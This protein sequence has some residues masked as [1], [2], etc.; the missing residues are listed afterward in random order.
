MSIW[1]K[2]RVSVLRRRVVVTAAVK[3]GSLV[4]AGQLRLEEARTSPFNFD[5]A[6]SFSEVEGMTARRALIPGSTVLRQW[7][8]TPVLIEKGETVTVESRVGGARLV[9]KAN[10]ETSGRLG[11]MI[12]VRNPTS[13]R[14]FQAKVVGSGKVEVGP[15]AY[16]YLLQT[17][18]RWAK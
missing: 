5:A 10:A 9:L 12:V 15:A 18:K 14:F 17:Q 6:E 7:L 3:A 4:L 8:V 2:A 11:G 1:A 16:S 13:G